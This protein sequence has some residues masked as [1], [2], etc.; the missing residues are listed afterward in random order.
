MMMTSQPHT[1][2]K[3]F[4]QFTLSGFFACLVIFLVP[5]TASAQEELHWCAYTKSNP[6]HGQSLFYLSDKDPDPSFD[7]GYYKLDLDVWP[8]DTRIGGSATLLIQFN[9]ATDRI[10]LELN[11]RLEISDILTEDESA[12]LSFMRSP[13]PVDFFVEI[14][15]PEVQQAGTSRLIRID[16]E[17]TPGS[18]G[19]GSFVFSQRAGQPHFWTLS[20]PFGARDW[21]PNKNTPA[22]KADSADII[23]RIPSGLKL[24]SNGLLHARTQ[25]DNNRTEW[26]WRTRYPTAHYL[27]SLA[28]A[29]YNEFTDYFH[30]APG[31]S[32]PVLNYVYSD[33]DTPMVREQIGLTI[34]ML[35][36][37]TELFGDY[38]FID[39]KYGHAQFG[40]G[41]GMEH[42]TMSSMGS[43][44]Q[45]LVAHELAHQWF[46]NGVTCAGWEDIWLN[47]GFAT[48]A[49]GLVI[50]H[51]EGDDAFRDWRAAHINQI[52][53]EPG[54]VYVPTASIDPADPGG[55]VARI[56]RFRTSYAKGAIVLHQLRYKLGDDLFFE[57][58]REWMQG[59]FRYKSATTED[60]QMHAEQVSGRSLTDFFN[61]WIYDE[62]VPSYTLRYA[63][64]PAAADESVTLQMRITERFTPDFNATGF[65]DNL[66]L[67]I[68]IP[69][70]AGQRDTT[71][72][73]HPEQYPFE[74][75]VALPFQ[76]GAPEI[77]PN[78]E[79]II[80][81]SDSIP[82]LFDDL[83]SE[84]PVSTQLLNP[85]PNPFN[86]A[87]IIP[88]LVGSP[89]EVTID[90]Y[91]INGR[92]VARLLNENRLTG[93]HHVRWDAS[94]Q[95]SGIYIIQLRTAEGQEVRKVSFVK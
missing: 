9:E 19:F 30:Y 31:D 3:P 24:G 22:V 2:R 56:F 8:E 89:G 64:R 80:G 10:T 11:R 83:E 71:I 28:G 85:Y 84:L 46:G 55:S 41:G 77:D 35:H 72:T 20:Q 44:S 75:N 38:P 25:L 53:Q 78:S 57:I 12:Q 60:F 86:P 58:L 81:Q 59:E 66:P 88:F 4:L 51:F 94:G 93:E 18:S 15:F 13:G 90:V 95:A 39:E 74:I 6:T 48:Y 68:R 70:A 62:A 23:V 61:L 76:P 32:M 14:S 21:F 92:L 50:E 67:T 7:V 47:E 26:H 52:I 54:R 49:E 69:E 29:S 27:L 34:D 1:V 33:N 37:F 65:S 91:D 16:Y 82:G 40:R 42:Q 73:F 45:R 17:G 5:R 43:F 63:S 87:T 79:R 36:L